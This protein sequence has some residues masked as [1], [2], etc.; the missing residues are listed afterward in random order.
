M[1]GDIEVLIVD[2]IFRISVLSR[3]LKYAVLYSEK[4]HSSMR[5]IC[6]MNLNVA[7]MTAQSPEC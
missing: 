1:L 6:Y 5:G 2:D 4:G 3:V 7:D